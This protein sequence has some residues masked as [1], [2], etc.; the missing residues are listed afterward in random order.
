MHL[1]SNVHAR[2]V[3]NEDLPRLL[4]AVIRLV[5]IVDVVAVCGRAE[6]NREILPKYIPK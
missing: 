6:K 2:K 3:E 4:K 5:A 1:H